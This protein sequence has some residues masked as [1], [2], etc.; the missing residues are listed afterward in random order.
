MYVCFLNLAPIP[1]YVKTLTG[2]IITIN[3]SPKQTIS[4][5]KA[6]IE[7]R[8][9]MPSSQARLV[10]EGNQLEDDHT[11]AE[12]NI[13][14]EAT[15]HLVLRLRGGGELCTKPC[16]CL[17]YAQHQLGVKKPN[18]KHHYSQLCICMFM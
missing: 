2:D 5:V 12:Y 13:G 6:T 11:L 8:I 17:W 1:V 7:D 3:S 14:K 16:I 10:Y 9:G 15:L 4:E 18:Q